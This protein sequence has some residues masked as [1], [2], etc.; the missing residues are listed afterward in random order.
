MLRLIKDESTDFVVMPCAS[1]PEALRKP[2]SVRKKRPEPAS[3]IHSATA[4]KEIS[5]KVKLFERA[6][7]EKQQ[8]ARFRF[9]IVQTWEQWL[10][11]KKG[12]E[13]F[14]AYIKAL[15]N[16]DLNYATLN[17]WRREA[18]KDPVAGLLDK[19]G[20]RRGDAVKINGWIKEYIENMF[21]GSFGNIR[22]MHLWKSL[23]AHAHREGKFEDFSKILNPTRAKQQGGQWQLIDRTSIS[24]Y[25][26]YLREKHAEYLLYHNNPDKYDALRE[27]AFGKADADVL[28]P[29]Q[30]W[31]ADASP[32]DVMTLRI[33]ENGELKQYRYKLIALIDVYSRMTIIDIVET[34]DTLAVAR[35][36]WRAFVTLGI[37]QMIRFDW[38][39]EFIAKSVRES[40]T[41]IGVVP[42]NCKPFKGRQKPFIER[43]FGTLQHS[44]SEM[45]EGYLGH[46]LKKR[47]EIESRIR[48]S[49]RLKGVKTN[50]PD[51]HNIDDI[52][53]ELNDWMTYVYAN[54]EHSGLGKSPAEA[55]Q[56]GII[57]RQP[58]RISDDQLHYVLGERLRDR[59]ITPKGIL[60]RHILYQS[61]ELTRFCG[62]KADLVIDM[63]NVRRAYAYDAETG[64]FLCS[65]RS[66]G[67]AMTAEE[68]KDA[69]KDY[70]ERLRE[71]ERTKKFA[72]NNCG[73]FGNMA[74]AII[75]AAKKEFTGS[76][77]GTE[78]D[79]NPDILVT[80][81]ESDRVISLKAIQSQAESDELRAEINSSVPDIR[82]IRRLVKE[83]DDKPAP[84]TL[85][86]MMG[87]V[88]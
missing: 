84:L 21:L 87:V 13:A 19:R 37:P 56:H 44:F 43:F 50:L 71:F 23:H 67:E 81:A 61:P 1:E 53:E 69:Y 82:E 29:N 49:E 75:E 85:K 68:R 66:Q 45:T 7:P 30:V 12:F 32:F 10:A 3:V 57:L 25:L 63:N 88:K 48:K 2:A 46:N 79:I 33:C 6:E 64:E 73:Q 59:S 74:S 41:H 11:Q 62:R 28:F 55:Y 5:S 54:T 58:E 16:I 9:E 39:K 14:Q 36:L 15:H 47:A 72:Q 26:D 20:R 17:V 76:F 65:L 40:L 4:K 86:Q 80:E 38:G 83:E 51:L 27:P 77:D 18:K 24:R 78:A 8:S 31:E 35:I 42:V 60:D 52:K 70:K 22:P 34:T